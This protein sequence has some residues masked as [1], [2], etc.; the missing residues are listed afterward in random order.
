MPLLL[1]PNLPPAPLSSRGPSASPTCSN[2]VFRELVPGLPAA[3]GQAAVQPLASRG[4]CRTVSLPGLF[5]ANLPAAQEE[6][7]CLLQQQPL[8][9]TSAK[10]QGSYF[11][12]QTTTCLYEWDT[13]TAH[14]KGGRTVFLGDGS[15]ENKQQHQCKPARLS[16]SPCRPE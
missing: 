1:L 10:G 6:K 14:P 9:L 13:N 15:A 11:W 12:F 5:P 2:S 7:W 8:L 4:R 16:S 3:A